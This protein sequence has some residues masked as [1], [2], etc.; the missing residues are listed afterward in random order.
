MRKLKT[1]KKDKKKKKKNKIKKV[2]VAGLALP[3]NGGHGHPG[4][5]TS[6]LVRF[7]HEGTSMALALYG[8]GPT[9]WPLWRSG[10]DL[11]AL[12]SHRG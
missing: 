11:L 3:I 4:G 6:S 8:F 12:N 1:R 7:G 10:L 2:S 5:W 9:P